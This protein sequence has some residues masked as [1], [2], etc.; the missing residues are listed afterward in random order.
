MEADVS[1]LVLL[2]TSAISVGVSGLTAWITA[3]LTR[4]SR[5][6]D[7][8]SEAKKKVYLDV[9]SAMLETNKG[10][11]PREEI[12]AEIAL[13]GSDGVVRAWNAMTDAQLD[14]GVQSAS[15]EIIPYMGD[16]LLALREDV[17]RAD[18]GLH[19]D[20]MLAAFGIRP[21]RK[22]PAKQR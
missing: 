16:L 7:D 21:G 5:I 14:Q 6:E 12:A 17:G 18:T 2:L 10:A 13:F 19:A 9:V 1:P 15:M 22:L 3:R 4:R 11:R 20:D 8:A